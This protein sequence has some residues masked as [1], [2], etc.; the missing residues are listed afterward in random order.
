MKLWW[1]A[2][3]CRPL[4]IPCP[5]YRYVK[6]YITN[7]FRFLKFCGIRHDW[8]LT[9]GFTSCRYQYEIYNLVLPSSNVSMK[10]DSSTGIRYRIGGAI[11]LYWLLVYDVEVPSLCRLTSDL[12][13]VNR[14]YAEQGKSILPMPL[15]EQFTENCVNIYACST[16]NFF[17]SLFFSFHIHILAFLQFRYLSLHSSLLRILFFWIKSRVSLVHS[18]LDVTCALSFTP[19]AISPIRAVCFPPSFQRSS[20]SNDKNHRELDKGQVKAKCL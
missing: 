1:K 2:I 6:L 4:N 8:D 5:L 16:M 20:I 17:S 3:R 19:F 10:S 18:R 12:L 7:Y 9:D 11:L 14:L 15:Q 13:V